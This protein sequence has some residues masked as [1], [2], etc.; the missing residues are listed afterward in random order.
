MKNKKII[1]IAA[2][3]L[4]IN[5]FFV[6]S[7][8][9]QKGPPL[10]PEIKGDKIAIPFD[11]THT[12]DQNQVTLFWK[13]EIDKETA[14]IKPEGFDIHMAKKTYQ[15]CAGCPFKFKKIG[16]VYIPATKFVLKIQQGFKYYFRIQAIGGD[17]VKSEYSKT[18]QVE[19]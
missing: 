9:G 18:I 17:D 8:C 5:L 4:L 1:I 14:V 11:L 2:L 16:S 10:P 3:A 15:E 6:F 13:H 12:L 7:G 19:N